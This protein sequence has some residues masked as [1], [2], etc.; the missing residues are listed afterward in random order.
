MA[1]QEVLSVSLFSPMTIS[2]L[3]ILMLVCFLVVVLPSIV[4]IYPFL[5]TRARR[6]LLLVATI[7]RASLIAVFFVGA[8]EIHYF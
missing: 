4:V 1:T 3:S 6:L 2:T 7:M 5:A 8:V